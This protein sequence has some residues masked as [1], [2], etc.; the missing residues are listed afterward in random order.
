MQK[1]SSSYSAFSF[2]LNTVAIDNVKL[3]SERWSSIGGIKGQWE[4]GGCHNCAVF[5][6]RK[7]VVSSLSLLAGEKKKIPMSISP[8]VGNQELGSAAG[9]G[10]G[11]SW[12][13][14]SLF[15]QQ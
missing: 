4:L 12:K 5:I 6:K 7:K 15:L 1:S 3:K 13:N 14:K 11:E 9:E 8:E 10:T 2:P